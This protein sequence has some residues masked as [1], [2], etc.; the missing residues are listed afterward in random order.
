[1]HNNSNKKNSNK[2]SQTNSIRIIAGEWRGRRLQVLD[3]AGLRP[4]TDRVRETLF[5]WLMLD[6]AGAR[7]LDL[8]AGTGAIG[9]E[10]LSRGASCVQFCELDK[11]AAELLKKNISV[12][13]SSVTMNSDSQTRRADV[14]CSNALD[15]LQNYCDNSFDLIFLDPPFDSVGMLREALALIQSRKLLVEGGIV[16]IEHNRKE[17]PFASMAEVALKDQNQT[18]VLSDYFVEYRV[19]VAGQTQFGLYIYRSEGV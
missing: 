9:L 5:N 14:H 7:C 11:S 19:Q 4:T 2:N 16:Y 17:N 1:M 10:G 12:L 3:K 8:F 15:Y 13:L 6:I 18:T